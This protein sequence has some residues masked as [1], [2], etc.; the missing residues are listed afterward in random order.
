MKTNKGDD[1]DLLALV[2][3]DPEP[4]TGKAARTPPK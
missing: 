1:V 4:Q 3:L 2:L